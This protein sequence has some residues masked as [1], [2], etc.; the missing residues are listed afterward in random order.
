MTFYYCHYKFEQ[1]HCL[2]DSTLLMIQPLLQQHYLMQ[3]CLIFI[4]YYYKIITIIMQ[5]LLHCIIINSKRNYERI[6]KTSFISV[7]RL[8]ILLSVWD[9]ECQGRLTSIWEI[10]R[11]YGLFNLQTLGI[12][13]DCQVIGMSII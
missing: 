2:R 13:I 10:V 3:K 8:L 1:G 5:C 4:N 11:Q 9:N 6:K 12:P 7:A